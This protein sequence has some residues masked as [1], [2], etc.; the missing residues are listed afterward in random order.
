M[1]M[2]SEPPSS[3]GNTNSPPPRVTNVCDEYISR[4]NNGDSYTLEQAVRKLEGQEQQLQVLSDL[5][6]FEIERWCQQNGRHP[7]C[8][9]LVLSHPGLKTEIASVYEKLDY[10]FRVPQTI[11][12]FRIVKVL[13][14]NSAQ[15]KVLKGRDDRIG[16]DVAIKQSDYPPNRERL[17]AEA[18]LLQRLNDGGKSQH[19]GILRVIGLV[20]TEESTALVVDYVEGETLY[21]VRHFDAK[22][23]VKIIAQVADAIEHAH[24][25]RICHQDISFNNIML[26]PSGSPV[27]IDFGM[28]VERDSWTAEVAELPDWGGTRQFYAP[29]R[30]L[31][32]ENYDLKLSEIFSL[33]AL[34]HWMLTGDFLIDDWFAE[35]RNGQNP[36]VYDPVKLAERTRELPGIRELLAKAI[37]YRPEDRFKSAGDFRDA[38][39]RV[40]TTADRKLFRP[41]NWA[42]GVTGIAVIA[43]VAVLLNRRPIES[44]QAKSPLIAAINDKLYND[45]AQ[46]TLQKALLVAD[47]DTLQQF[48]E[49]SFHTQDLNASLASS[50]R[51]NDPATQ[52]RVA[53]RFFIRSRGNKEAMDWFSGRLKAGLDPNLLLPSKDSGETALLYSALEA[54]NA[55]AVL[56]LLKSGASPHPYSKLLGTRTYSPQFLFPIWKLPEHGFSPVEIGQIIAAMQQSGLVVTRPHEDE[57]P[58]ESP[59]FLLR[60]DK[61]PLAKI[62]ARYGVPLVPTESL[63]TRPESIIAEQAT[64]RGP[65]DWNAF[66]QAMPKTFVCAER[67]DG[68]SIDGA[69]IKYLLAIHGDRAYFYGECEF[70]RKKR[71]VLFSTIIHSTRWTMYLRYRPIAGSHGS[72]LPVAGDKYP[73]MAYDD[74]C[75]RGIHFQYDAER[76]EIRYENPNCETT[77]RVYCSPEEL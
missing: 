76:G 42:I 27:V 16:Q 38:L 6:P 3:S 51:A 59:Y 22:Q 47:V 28:A 26:T 61:N 69:S 57:E 29:E 33:G 58:E 19:A 20:E 36:L 70:R 9:E 17:R 50:L 14:E 41:R 45:V 73:E 62:S 53:E 34:L 37:A 39:D 5:L 55:E 48:T 40:L 64:R 56:T 32:Q 60:A 1:T 23:A 54:C 30:Y 43:M 68:N 52:S 15:G 77:Y 46:S 2:G 12:D 18:A 24:L 35:N 44:E 67:M 66:L 65:H 21:S 75:W 4:C 7:C 13:C 25:R 8:A 49:A 11:G 10:D 71:C 72:P 31:N 74:W 63:W